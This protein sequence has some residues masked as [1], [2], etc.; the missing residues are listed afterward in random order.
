[1][2]NPW[3]SAQIIFYPGTA[4]FT[5]STSIVLGHLFLS[6]L[7]TALSTPQFFVP[8]TANPTLDI[9][10]GYLDIDLTGVSSTSAI[11]LNGTAGGNG[12][13]GVQTIRSIRCLWDVAGN[14]P[15]VYHQT[16]RNTGLGYTYSGFWQSAQSDIR[17]SENKIAVMG[18]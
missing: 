8:G 2:R 9:D 12:F 13:I 11:I 5:N 15:R 14:I 18:G 10:M 6:G 3:G 17:G 4:A 16:R 1:M 7:F